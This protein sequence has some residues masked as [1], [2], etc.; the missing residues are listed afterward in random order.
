MAGTC[1]KYCL[2]SP[3]AFLSPLHF[4]LHQNQN[5]L[6]RRWANVNSFRPIRFYMCSCQL[7]DAFFAI[8]FLLGFLC[9]SVWV[10]S[11]V[12]ICLFFRKPLPPCKINYFCF[13]SLAD[14][15]VL[16][17]SNVFFSRS[18]SFNPHI[19]FTRII[20]CSAISLC[21]LC[22]WTWGTQKK[23]IIYFFVVVFVVSSAYGLS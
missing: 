9:R 5:T 13:F 11:S 2:I 8:S 20:R 16:V 3:K 4:S 14:F 23:E 6:I 22:T 7:V 19:N 15:P 10:V 1:W 18:T 12:S 21:A 17:L